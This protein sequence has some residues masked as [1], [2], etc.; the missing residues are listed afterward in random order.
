MRVYGHVG[1]DFSVRIGL[2]QAAIVF[3]LIIPPI[4]VFYHG[5]PEICWVRKISSASTFPAEQTLER[6]S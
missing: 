2:D 1:T 5:A 4:V 6:W 3:D